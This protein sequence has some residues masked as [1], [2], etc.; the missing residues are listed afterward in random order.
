MAQSDRK[1]ILLVATDRVSGRE[2]TGLARRIQAA[3]RNRAMVWW[4]GRYPG[5]EREAKSAATEVTVIGVPRGCGSVPAAKKPGGAGGSVR[6]WI[7]AKV[8]RSPW[9]SYYYHQQRLQGLIAQTGRILADN[10]IDA[11]ILPYDSV[12][13]DSP[14]VV[15]AGHRWG[16][17]SIIIPFTVASASEAAEGY[18]LDADYGLTSW[19]NRAFAARHPH[20]VYHHRGRDLL[21]LPAGWAW[22][23]ISLGLAPPKPWVLHSGRTDALAVESEFM[24]DH[25]RAEGL[26][27]AKLHLTGS[28]ADD[29]LAAG[30]A[31][32]EVAR[33]ELVSGLGLTVKTS[34][35][36]CAVPPNA[37]TLKRLGNEFDDYLQIIRAMIE[38]LARTG[39]WNVVL[40]PHPDMPA[41]LL[42]GFTGP[43]VALS[44]FP[45]AELIPLCDLYVA[46]ISATIRWAAACGKPVVNYDVYRFHY[47]DYAQ[48]PGVITVYD[49][50]AYR[51]ALAQAAKPDYRADLAARQQAVA[52]RFGILDG[53]SVDRIIDLA[54]KLA[55]AGKTARPR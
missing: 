46:S 5:W 22:S 19:P 44:D 20:W 17:A 55:R 16:V 14:A 31:R 34:L 53:R 35:A 25:Y 8:K 33:A 38:P 10:A 7:A 45:I 37:L 23:L 24:A 40:A 52:A 15:A 29:V 43:N 1:N 51:R 21:R 12:S 18:F 3:G 6:S 50:A 48:T 32:S 9:L 49:Q 28:P 11:L 26:P 13:S 39:D 54:D 2:F 4:R 47:D 36:V 42:E 27:E 41:Q 30:M